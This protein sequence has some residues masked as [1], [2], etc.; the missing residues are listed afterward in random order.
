MRPSWF[1][2]EHAL[3]Y[4]ATK[5]LHKHCHSGNKI[6]IGHLQKKTVTQ[7]LG[8]SG[9]HLAVCQRKHWNA[10]DSKNILVD[11]VSVVRNQRPCNDV[12]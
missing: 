7:P 12:K 4:E 11:I 6:F 5:T 1:L 3:F 8:L 2:E 9:H 10:R